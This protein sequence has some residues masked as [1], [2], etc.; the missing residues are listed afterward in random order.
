MACARRFLLG[1]WPKISLGR[2]ILP[3]DPPSMLK[4]G[5]ESLDIVVVVFA[6]AFLVTT[7]S[8]AIFVLLLGFLMWSGLTGFTVI[9]LLGILFHL[10]IFSSYRVF[11]IG[12][13]HSRLVSIPGN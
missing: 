2:A 7:D 3:C 8:I 11:L 1:F 5:T 13:G 12:L 9:V 4:R 6:L 10:G